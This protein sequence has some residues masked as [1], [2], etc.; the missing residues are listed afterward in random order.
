M[1][2]DE[3]KSEVGPKAAQKRREGDM[4]PAG[5]R[6]AC[7]AFLASFLGGC[8]PVDPDEPF[9][10]RTQRTAEMHPTV[11]AG[12]TF[13]YEPA[14][15]STE[16]PARGDVV[17]FNNGSGVFL[18]SRVIGVGGD[19]VQMRAGRLYLNGVLI[20]RTFVHRARGDLATV[21]ADVIAYREQLPGMSAP[22]LIHE[23]SDDDALSETP[24]FLVPEGRLF[25]MGDN[26]DNSGDSRIPDGHPDLFSSRSD[27]WRNWRGP[28]YRNQ[29]GYLPIANVVGRLVLAPS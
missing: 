15:Y 17:L 5:N 11:S 29:Y 23:V 6:S 22:Y 14:A 19:Q 20:E 18:I 2:L 1:R 16:S 13:Q 8:S 4:S 25:L 27:E 28:A 3:K 7:L 9:P 12:E 26:R 24:V 21:G 10:S